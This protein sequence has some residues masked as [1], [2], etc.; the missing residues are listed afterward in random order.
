MSI[1][2][3]R[4]T[5][6]GDTN[7]KLSLLVINSS[8]NFQLKCTL[9]DHKPLESIFTKP[10]GSIPASNVTEIW[11]VSQIYVS[12][13]LLYVVDTL[14]ILYTCFWQLSSSTYKHDKELAVYQF[15]L[16]I[17]IA[18]PQKEAQKKCY[19]SSCVSL[20]RDGQQ[21][22]KCSSRCLWVLECTK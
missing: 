13:K 14:A 15:I 3:E 1:Y 19:N 11:F 2:T 12:S 10:L 17:T 7:Q 20:T 16:H 18:K 4:I 22:H 8:M 21:H 6:V 9:H 5:Q